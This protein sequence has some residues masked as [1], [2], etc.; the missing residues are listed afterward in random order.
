MIVFL[1][2]NIHF[3]IWFYPLWPYLV[4]VTSISNIGTRQLTLYRLFLIKCVLLDVITHSIEHPWTVKQLT[5]DLPCDVISDPEVNEINLPSTVFTA[6][7]A[8]YNQTPTG[9]GVVST[10]PFVKF[11]PSML[12]LESPGRSL[13]KCNVLSSMNKTTKKKN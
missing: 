9:R 8:R 5:F 3:K 7:R 6:T 2:K 10:L 12:D 13:Q 4:S 11:R 1:P